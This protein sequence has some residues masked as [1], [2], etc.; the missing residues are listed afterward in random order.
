LST[1]PGRGCAAVGTPRPTVGA[2]WAPPT[3]HPSVAMEA[4]RVGEQ[5]GSPTGVH[6]ESTGCRG[7]SR[8]R[9][10]LGIDD[11]LAAGRAD[12]LPPD[13]SG[14]RERRGE[15]RLGG[16]ERRATGR[17]RRKPSYGVAPLPPAAPWA[18]DGAG[19]FV[20]HRRWIGRAR[21]A[22]HFLRCACPR[23]KR[24]DLA[25]LRSA[26]RR[27]ARF[28]AAPRVCRHPSQRP[29]AG[30]G[31]ARNDCSSGRRNPTRPWDVGRSVIVVAL[32]GVAGVVLG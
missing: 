1:T 21:P 32:V 16:S 22:R 11:R 6:A 14:R 2:R 4:L 9:L 13:A 31:S 20:G 27:P 24:T 12:F 17:A 30:V 5:S 8:R 25:G 15:D 3:A 28:R 26:G 7:S 19:G 23:W 18:T 10:G 29:T